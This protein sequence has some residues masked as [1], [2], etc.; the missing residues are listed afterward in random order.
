MKKVFIILNILL[1]TL[2]LISC[3]DNNTPPQKEEPKDD[4]IE[5]IVEEKHYE[6]PLGSDGDV[7]RINITTKDNVFP[8]DKETYI[9]GSLNVTE[10][11]TS[12]VKHE[13]M[14]M[15]IKLRG[16]STIAAKKKPFKIKFDSKQSLFGLT[17]AKEWVLLANYYDKTNIRNF[18]AYNLANKLDLGFQP[19]SIFVDVYFN[20]EY[21]GLYMLTEQM[22]ANEGRVDIKN[23]VSSDGIN[24]FLLEADDRAKDEYPGYEGHCYIVSG[25]YNFALKYPDADDY[26]D[27][28]KEN[29][30]K[31]VEEFAKDIKW[32]KSYI[33]E[34][35]Y[36]ISTNDYGIYSQYIDVES[37]IDYYIVQELFKNLDIAST[38]QY[39]I[40]NQNSNNVRLEMGPVWDFDLAAGVVDGTSDKVYENYAKTALFVKETDPYYKE[41][42]KDEVFINLLKKRYTEIRSELIDPILGELDYIYNITSK[43]QL[44]NIEKWPLTKDRNT[45]VEM[46]ALSINYYDIESLYGHYEHLKKVL[47][48]RIELLDD[49]YLIK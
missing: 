21:I 29:D 17:E 28:I 33:K 43:A 22:E 13:T 18:L 39:Y 14:S 16:N 46:Y 4:P 9:K 49:N 30:L 44:R 7:Y 24:S 45:W 10:Q 25:R 38:S 34:V 40:I 3:N 2:V 5:D 36:A 35:S 12:L 42:F 26:V 31:T 37:F 19:S 23:N 11:D 32:L 8:S 48:E 6:Q 1:L 27:A 41:L 15:K 47:K 20:N